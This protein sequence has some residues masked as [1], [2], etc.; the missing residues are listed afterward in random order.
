MSRRVPPR[1]FFDGESPFGW[2]ASAE[3]LEGRS[4]PLV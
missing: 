2:Y 1:G 4:F 3:S